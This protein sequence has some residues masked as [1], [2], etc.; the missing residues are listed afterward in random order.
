MAALNH[1]EPDDIL[2]VLIIGAG[3]SGIN[4][5]YYLTTYGPKEQTYAIL[6]GRS[7][8]G[9]TWDLF[10]YPGIRCDSDI[11][12]FSFGWNPWPGEKL[13]VGGPELCQYMRQSV[14][15]I[16][17]DKHIIFNTMVRSVSWS[18]NEIVW[19][20]NA[21]VDGKGQQVYKSRFIILGTG[22][23]DY[24]NPQDYIIP[25]LKT[26]KGD[27]IEPQFW[28]DE[29]D[30]EDKDVVI[31]GSGAT[32]VTILPNI[33]A[34]TKHTT[35]LQRSPTYI[36]TMANRMPVV[37]RMAR[38]YL[39]AR[40][41]HWVSRM[42]HMFKSYTSYSYVVKNP[43]KVK[44]LIMARMEQQLPP[45][46]PVNPHFSPRY[47]PWEQRLCVCPDGD[48]WA[49]LRS[50]KADVVTDE[51]DHVSETEIHLKSGK[52]IPADTLI[53][54]TGIKLQFAGGIEIYVDGELIEPSQK[55]GWK[56]CMIQDVPNLAFIVGYVNASWTLGSDASSYLLM[57]LLRTMKT[58]SAASVTP[59][60]PKNAEMKVE[61]CFKLG[62]TYLK[63]TLAVF[64]KDG[65]GQFRFKTQYMSDM[66]DATWGDIVTDLEFR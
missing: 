18:S 66:W 4:A 47:N 15:K 37:D 21:I 9:G 22:Y 14:E 17:A 29:P 63:N 2:D 24:H 23:Y 48:F 7:A 56:G 36:A 34:K 61:P 32:A 52:E 20:I 59:R 27:L 26:F 64:P 35:M 3:I 39:P 53:L 1:V 28:P 44:S 38:D 6:E 58:K 46:I 43:E 40:L 51:I 54:A 25:G 11:L 8:I 50:G 45:H 49:A 10:R 30:L 31:I 19:T 65:E 12:T 62:S 60:V 57:R 33:A 16:G 55:F 42:Y 5:A 41:A 13:L